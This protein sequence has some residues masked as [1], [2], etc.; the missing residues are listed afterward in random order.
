MNTAGGGAPILQFE[1]C[2]FQNMNDVAIFHQ[3]ANGFAD[4]PNKLDRCQI[5]GSTHFKVIDGQ[6]ADE[7]FL[8]TNST[9]H[10]TSSVTNTNYVDCGDDNRVNGIIRN[11]S[12]LTGY[13]GNIDIIR[14][15]I[16]EN[17]ILRNTGSGT[18]TT[19][20]QANA[21]RANNCTFGNFDVAQ[22]G[23]ISGSSITSN[24]LFVNELSNPPNFELQ[25]GSPCIDAGKTIA[26]IT[27][28]FA[29]SAR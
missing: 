14:F 6:N 26:S 11:C 2:T 23:S 27:V 15:G 21:S 3:P 13:S 19:G 8:F 22:T 1:Q 7:H 16:I 5:K 9:F 10:S 24:P 4:K 18:Q 12:F 25:E 20:I 17:T 29:G 28:D